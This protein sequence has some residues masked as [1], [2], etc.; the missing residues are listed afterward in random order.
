MVQ[1][2]SSCVGDN[3]ATVENEAHDVISASAKPQGPAFD[4]EK[5]RA[6]KPAVSDTVVIA[7]G[8]H[9]IRYGHAN[10]SLPKKVRAVV[11][12]PRRKDATT[13]PIYS[14]GRNR[15][16][17]VTGSGTPPANAFDSIVEVIAADTE[18]HQRRRGG[19]KPIPWDVEVEPVDVPD[20]PEVVEV[21][22][23]G[24]LVGRAAERVMLGAEAERSQYDIIAPLADGRMAWSADC[25][26]GLVRAGLDSLLRYI[27]LQ[28]LW[29]PANGADEETSRERMTYIALIVPDSS[30]RSDMAEFIAA[31][32]RVDELRMAAVFVHHSSAAC[33]LGAGLSTCAVVDVGHTTTT[34]A[35]VEEGCVLG[36]SRLHL[37][38]GAQSVVGSFER[39]ARRSNAFE[40]IVKD[41]GADDVRLL[42]ARASK[43]LC[44][45]NADENDTLSI[46]MARAP[47]SGKMYRVKC[48]VGIRTI[49]AHGVFFPKLLEAMTGISGLS[50][51]RIAKPAVDRNADEDNFMLG[52]FDDIKR[53]ATVLAAV[54]FGIFANE[55]VDVLRNEDSPIHPVNAS[56]VDA[57]IWS[58]NRAVETSVLTQADSH[59]GPELRRRYFN[60]VLLAGGG[61]SI[62]GIGLALERSIKNALSKIGVEVS[63]VTVI[64]GGK[65][66]GDEELIAAAEVSNADADGGDADED[67][68]PACL[69]WKGGAVLVEADAVKD[70][71]MF[72]DEWQGRGVRALREKVPFYW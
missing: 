43:H 17:E 71:W 39:L 12:F 66:K 37:Q 1:T 65:G 68:D 30:D 5:A 49:P 56:I 25:S 57:I 63:D 47:K 14:V 50:R 11:A 35:C 70:G 62:D 31:L 20:L 72:R 61:S 46:V 41:I 44:S 64:D 19:G 55:S 33:A 4:G 69:P 60:S 24:V 9:A 48:G 58:V 16:V 29:H 15:T 3:L 6:F 13:K 18:L 21:K 51:T 27:A 8:S 22:A 36:D 53:S 23:D 45:F 54:P 2:P 32:H 42:V 10:A 38:Y 67:G 40:G 26:S 59:R 52:L 7:L 28:L 34:I